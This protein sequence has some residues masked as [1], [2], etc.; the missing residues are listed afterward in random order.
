MPSARKISSSDIGRNATKILSVFLR[1]F[2]IEHDFPI[3]KIANTD[4]V[5]YKYQFVRLLCDFLFIY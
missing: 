3:T 1:V 5:F 4:C 2:F